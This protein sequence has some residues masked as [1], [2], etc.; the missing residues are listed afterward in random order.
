ML[1]DDV[2][3]A[4]QN[5]LFLAHLMAPHF[6]WVYRADGTVRPLSEMVGIPEAEPTLRE[7]PLYQVRHARYAA[8][9]QYLTAPGGVS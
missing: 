2:L 3:V 6:S 4:Q 7:N 9:V 1:Q 8:Q 5:T